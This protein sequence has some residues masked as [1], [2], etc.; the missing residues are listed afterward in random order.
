MSALL[1]T[2]TSA[3]SRMPALI[4]CTLSPRFGVKTT[5]V[6]SATAAT[7]SSD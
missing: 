7:S 2:K 1:T 3:I 6:V 4:I 5:T